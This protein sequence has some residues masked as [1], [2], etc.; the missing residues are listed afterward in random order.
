MIG[1]STVVGLIATTSSSVSFEYFQAAFYTNVFEIGYRRSFCLQIARS[2][3]QFSSTGFFAGQLGFGI[4][5]EIDDVMTT[6][7]SF[8]ALDAFNTFNVPSINGNTNQKSIV[9]RVVSKPSRTMT[10]DQTK[11][12]YASPVAAVLLNTIYV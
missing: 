6:R 2:V 12:E 8:A 11:A 3:Q 7:F 9:S 5:E 10:V 4:M 1:S